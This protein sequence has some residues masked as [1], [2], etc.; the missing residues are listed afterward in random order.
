MRRACLFKGVVGF[1][2]LRGEYS[3]KEAETGP[4]VVLAILTSFRPLNVTSMKPRSWTIDLFERHA[5]RMLV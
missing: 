4:F 3:A 5:A 2:S 1:W